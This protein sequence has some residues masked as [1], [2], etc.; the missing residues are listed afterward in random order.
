MCERNRGIATNLYI[1]CPK[2][3][4][5]ENLISN[6]RTSAAN[7]RIN[8]LKISDYDINVRLTLAAMMIGG[9]R[10]EMLMLMSLLNSPETTFSHYREMEDTIKYTPYALTIGD[11]IDHPEFTIKLTDCTQKVHVRRPGRG[12]EGILDSRRR[13]SYA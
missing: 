5:K 6:M 3:K 9:G 4:W 1:S 8:Y 10:T 7:K 13:A 2:W 12:Q 11:T